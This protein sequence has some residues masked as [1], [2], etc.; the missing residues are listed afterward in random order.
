MTT[1]TPTPF[2]LLVVCT[3]NICRSPAAERL[4]TAG[5][6]PDSGVRVHSAGTF[7]VVDD[8]VSAP[9]A[10]LITTAGADAGRFAARQLTASMVREAELVLAL[11]RAHRSLVVELH[12]A[13]VRRT[14]TL[15]ELARL[16]AGVDPAA[17]PAGTPA[18]R[19]AALLPLAAAERGRHLV[20][21]SED[22]VLDPYGRSERVYAGVF[23]QIHAA[24]DTIVRL[25]RD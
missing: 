18:E 7:A 14:F 22:D 16:A 12:P 11:T 8:P 17:L 13:A 6:G 20:Q 24:T 15:R 1:P 10:A 3:G 21:P 9:M 25:V 19:L 23:A 2:D 4:L 5:L